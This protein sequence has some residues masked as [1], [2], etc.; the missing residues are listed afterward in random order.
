FGSSTLKVYT[1]LGYHYWNRG[2]QDIHDG[3]ADYG[4]QY[5]WLVL[6][7]GVRWEQQLTRRFSIDLDVSLQYSFAGSVKADMS[8]VDP[9]LADTLLPLGAKPGYRIQLP[10]NYQLTQ[11]FALGFTPWLEY[12]ALGAS[13]AVALQTSSGQQVT[14]NSGNPI[15]ISE[16]S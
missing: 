1:G 3:V 5:S 9:H 10:F 12:S 11:S 16:P 2:Q 13:S 15:G 8:Q 7:L 6:P 14:D 4:E